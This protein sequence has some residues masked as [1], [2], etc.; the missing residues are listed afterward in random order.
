MELAE[1][2]RY[3]E[4]RNIEEYVISICL[5]NKQALAKAVSNLRSLR[6]F[7]DVKN[8]QAF[9]IIEMFY[10]Q[11]KDVDPVV[12]IDEWI[13]LEIYD[14]GEARQVASAY[15]GDTD[16]EPK[17]EQLKKMGGMRKA[18][19][20]IGKLHQ[21]S[22]K[23]T[24]PENLASKAFDMAVSWN[25]GSH[26]KY[27]TAKEVEEQE[28][29][30][31][32]GEKLDIGIPLFDDQV[33]KNAGLNKGTM[34]AIMFREKHGKTRSTC[35]EVAQHLRQG[36]TVLYV[37]LE[38]QNKK[39]KGNVKQILQSE[40]KDHYDRLLLKDS[41]VVV[42]EIRS[43]IIEACFVDEVDVVVVDYLQRMELNTDKFISEN[44]K[45]NEC[46]K[47]LTDLCVKYDFLL[48]L[49]SQA[50]SQEKQKKG[51]GN[52]PDVYDAYGSKQIIKDASMIMIGFRPSWYEELI[53]KDPMSGKLY[54]TDPN[55]QRCPYSS[56]FVK[57]VLSREKLDIAHQ[58]VHMIDTD[59]G[60]K[61]HSQNLI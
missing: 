19:K 23:N 1:K 11:G 13:D 54:A 16:F 21:L 32:V 35:W 7:K 48:N 33:Y 58:Y 47:A 29:N 5:H 18:K 17:I 39:I 51:Y 27:Y 40:W 30:N 9:G 55:E 57:P 34:K 3:W 59:Q 12:L 4:A 38:G 31:E 49:L 22:T 36:R 37:T 45:F 60:L 2:T 56:V 50:T 61:L 15:E 8:R 20:D 28:Q 25:N 6:D 52:V 14:K 44:V 26:K 24:S 10:D 42:D 53:Q 41:A 46:C 43:A